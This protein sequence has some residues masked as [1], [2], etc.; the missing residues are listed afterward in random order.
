MISVRLEGNGFSHMRRCRADVKK[1]KLC[2]FEKH[3]KMARFG[4][5]PVATRCKNLKQK[6]GSRKNEVKRC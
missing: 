6:S 2:N 1:K 5:L 3:L 4:S